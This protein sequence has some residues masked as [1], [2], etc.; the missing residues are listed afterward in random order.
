MWNPNHRKNGTGILYSYL[1]SLGGR[2][3]GHLNVSILLQ[4][5]IS[6][7]PNNCFVILDWTFNEENSPRKVGRVLNFVGIFYCRR[8]FK[9]TFG[10]LGYYSCLLHTVAMYITCTLILFLV[11]ATNFYFYLA[12]GVFSQ[13]ISWLAGFRPAV[14]LENVVFFFR[15]FR[16]TA[17]TQSRKFETNIPRKGIAQPQS[18]FL[19]SCVFERFIYIPFCLFCCRKI[20]GPF[21]GIYKSLTDTWMWELGLWPRNSFS[22]NICFEFSGLCLCSA[23]KKTKKK[24]TFSKTTAG[25]KPANQLI[26][27][28]NTPF[29][30]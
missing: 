28:E 4:L 26:I 2:G 7:Y 23:A 1:F 3:G 27:W 10:I 21:L 12:K 5:N 20:C 29:A 11:F 15:F 16:C 13:M 19:H 22:G 25:R 17:K 8:C 14:V 6:H 24:P 18:Q 9:F 30:K